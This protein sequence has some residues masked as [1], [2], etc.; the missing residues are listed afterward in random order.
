M[1][2]SVRKLR[3]CSTD[4]LQYESLLIA[5]NIILLFHFCPRD[6]IIFCFI[7]LSITLV[8]WF[9]S[10]LCDDSKKRFLFLATFT[11]Q[12]FPATEGQTNRYIITV[13]I[14]QQFQFRDASVVMRRQFYDASVLGMVRRFR[15]NK[16]KIL[17][18]GLGRVCYVFFP[19][20][21]LK[22]IL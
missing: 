1:F 16:T 17:G 13:V 2:V 11:Y 21:S 22:L 14:Q 20:T 5:G 8:K 19:K 12:P 3:L 18:T 15:E 6:L 7:G 10:V 9:W 4:A